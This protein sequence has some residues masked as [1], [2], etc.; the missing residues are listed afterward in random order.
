[1]YCSYNIIDLYSFITYFTY[2]ERFVHFYVPLF[3]KMIHGYE[4][5]YIFRFCMLN[6]C[7]L[8]NGF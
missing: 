6:E 3:I 5:G 2:Y 4:K 7:A 8:M 1:M